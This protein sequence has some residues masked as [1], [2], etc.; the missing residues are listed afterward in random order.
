MPDPCTRLFRLA[1]KW[2]KTAGG[3]LLTVAST[4]GGFAWSQWTSLQN[5]VGNVETA[6]TR[7]YTDS[8]V[9]K[10]TVVNLS[11]NFEDF[12]NEYRQD[13]GDIRRALM[14]PPARNTAA[15]YRKETAVV[16]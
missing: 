9:S 8:E 3:I 1:T 5:R 2:K 11:R 15:V 12:R 7:A 4:V 6:Q 16:P 10:Q 14:I 13:V